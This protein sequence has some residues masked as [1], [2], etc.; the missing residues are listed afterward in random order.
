M[1]MWACSTSLQESRRIIRLKG[2]RPR[3][4]LLRALTTTHPS[5]A[6]IYNQKNRMWF[7]FFF[8]FFFSILARASWLAQV[9]SSAGNLTIHD[10]SL[11]F[12]SSLHHDT[13]PHSLIF[14]DTTQLSDNDRQRPP[15]ARKTSE[16]RVSI[17]EKSVRRARDTTR[18]S[19][20]RSSTSC[21]FCE[22]REPTR[23][24]I[25]ADAA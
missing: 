24:G 5:Y 25:D 11:H 8:V 16:K 13:L 7:G 6:V 2:C 20:L 3:S 22:A 18:S 14:D 9:W 15:R 23:A 19:S 21:F 1:R 4:C 10:L 17:A 12:Y